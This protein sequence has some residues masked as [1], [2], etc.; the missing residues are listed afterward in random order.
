MNDKQISVSYEV[1]RFH[2][3]FSN[4]SGRTLIARVASA[5]VTHR[6]HDGDRSSEHETSNPIETR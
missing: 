4:G 2:L 5:A 6:K 1:L 3:C